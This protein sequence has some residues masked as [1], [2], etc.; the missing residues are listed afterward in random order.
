MQKKRLNTPIF[1]FED[2]VDY[3][4]EWYLYAKRFGLTQREFLREAGINANAFL[5]DVLARRKKIGKRHIHG[6][7]KALGLKNDEQDY[8]TLLVRKELCREPA[9]KIAIFNNLAMIRK[10]N[11]STM[12]DNR[13]MEYYASWRYPVI[14]EY[15]LW[16]GN[17]SSP[18]EIAN[19]LVNL[20]LST[21]E[22]EMA[23]SKLAAWNMITSDGPGRSYRPVENGS[24][25]YSSMPHPVVNDVKR[26]FIEAAVH[27]MEEMPRNQRHISM[28]IKGLS[29][30]SYQ[31]LCLKIDALR[32]EF[33]EREENKDAIDRVVSLNIQAFPVMKIDRTQLRGGCSDE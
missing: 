21:H 16:R 3:L 25:T 33:L 4:R 28:A 22:I 15:I 1:I 27:A 2:H 23:L 19:A 32:R 10:Q 13:T 14:R 17:V 5:S 7:V 9:D 12:L 8:F 29:E 31:E 24:I 11:L 6:F 20:K 18:K 26:T 30:K